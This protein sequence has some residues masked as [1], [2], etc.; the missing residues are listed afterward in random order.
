MTEQRPKAKK[1]VTRQ[2]RTT[3]E[4]SRVV[5]ARELEGSKMPRVIPRGNAE[6]CFITD[7]SHCAVLP[8]FFTF[9]VNINRVL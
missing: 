3:N 7:V 5:P 4:L 9:K 1:Q 8:L 6:H 2:G